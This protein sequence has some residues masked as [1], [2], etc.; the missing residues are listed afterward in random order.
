MYSY[1]P[2]PTNFIRVV[3]IHPGQFDDDIAITLHPERF[4]PA[5]I[6]SPVFPR[7]E[8]LSYT[9]GSKD[10]PAQV[11]VQGFADC[12]IEVTRNL[13]VAL[14]HLRQADQSRLMWI[15]A[16]CIDQLNN[17]EKGPQVGMM[18]DIYR[19]AESVVVWLGP[20]ENDSD[21]AMWLMEAIGAEI[22]VDFDTCEM[23]PS[24]IATDLTL[25]DESATI[26]IDEEGLCSL[27]HLFCRSWFERLWIRQELALANESALF[28][29][30]FRSVRWQ[31]FKRAWACFYLKPKPSFK[32]SDELT[33][34]NNSL[35]GL[36]FQE[37]GR[38]LPHLR[39]GFG[40]AQCSD[41][42]DRIYALL[43][44]DKTMEDLGIVPDYSVTAT[45]LYENVAR[46]FMDHFLGLEILTECEMACGVGNWEGPSWVPD[47]SVGNPYILHLSSGVTY[48]S[49]P[50]VGP[51][52]PVVDHRL[53]VIGVPFDTIQNLEQ[54]LVAKSALPHN[55]DTQMAVKQMLLG[56]DLS[57]SYVGGE[58]LL[59]AYVRTFTLDQ[60]AETYSPA[61]TS[62]PR[63]AESVE[64]MMKLNSHAEGSPLIEDE[65]RLFD[66]LEDVLSGR[67]LLETTK[68]YIGLVPPSALPS[69]EIYI[70]L[71]SSLPIVLRHT[72]SGHYKVV[73]A[74]Y[75]CGL[76][77]GEAILGP[78]PQGF[79]F[80]QMWDGEGYVEGF[81]NQ[82]T[83]EVLEE[84]PRL[85]A[86]PTGD[87][88]RFMAISG[89]IGERIVVD[90][91][92]LGD[93]GINATYI[94]LV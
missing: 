43:S 94:E 66:R 19:L 53:T 76:N 68:K 59:D 25:S 16:V 82:D 69:D 28:V 7:Y 33:N 64:L 88:T 65:Q 22:E 27:Y 89:S 5:V 74:C 79:R 62:Y 52:L 6:P 45:Q 77:D 80:V 72:D 20:E 73:G 39:E 29:C 55:D 12:I 54:P 14:R 48:A 75:V 35:S 61:T 83:G 44:L 51:R 15:D 93:R 86:W 78:M 3:E 8:A 60:F 71:G 58:T 18:G 67:L 34:R 38:H 1:D 46:L 91:K 57:R 90:V 24:S 47:W 4:D 63:F 40:N 81:I 23:K 17:V 92:Y 84:D 70:I 41:P 10:N 11:Q 56:K 50:F 87:L 21:S 2:L 42:R 30:G 37:V 49:G 32:F 85:K 36:L 9:W 31:V 13:D 26:S